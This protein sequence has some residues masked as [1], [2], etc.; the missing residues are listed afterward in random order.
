MEDQLIAQLQDIANASS[1]AGSQAKRQQAEIDLQRSRG[2]PAFPTALVNVGS[3]ASVDG[4]V[5]ALAMTTLNKFIQRNWAHDE[6]TEEPLI[7]ISEETRQGLRNAL[8]A[9]ALNNEDNRKI[10]ALTR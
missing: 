10:K 6:E 3:H 9:L 4:A 8:L 1:A 7:D 5:R 2:N